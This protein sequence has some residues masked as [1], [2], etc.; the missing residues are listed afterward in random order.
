MHISSSRIKLSA[1]LGTKPSAPRQT[2]RTS[3]GQIK[4]W[5]LVWGVLNPASAP[6]PSAGA[7]ADEAKGTLQKG[8]QPTNAASLLQPIYTHVYTQQLKARTILHITY[9][10]GRVDGGPAGGLISGPD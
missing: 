2:P 8:G 1:A 10:A 3:C 4:P 6:L 9:L 7:R 5:R